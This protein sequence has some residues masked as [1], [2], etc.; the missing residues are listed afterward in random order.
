MPQSD[1]FG[2][3]VLKQIFEERSGQ[4]YFIT[5]P[6]QGAKTYVL[7]IHL[8]GSDFQNGRFGKCP[9]QI[10]EEG[11]RHPYFIIFYHSISHLPFGE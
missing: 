10:L 5:L 2:T 7:L 8:G 1:H 9:Q 6:L 4:P 11:C 3:P